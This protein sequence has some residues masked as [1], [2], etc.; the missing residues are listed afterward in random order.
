MLLRSLRKDERAGALEPGRSRRC[1]AIVVCP[2]T[3]ALGFLW[4]V[5]WRGSDRVNCHTRPLKVRHGPQWALGLALLPLAFKSLRSLFSLRRYYSALYSSVFS[6][7]HVESLVLV[8]VL[9]A[10]C[11]FSC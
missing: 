1:Q 11:S 2:L 5:W 9:V 10:S 7:Q 6:L 8:R 4:L 3:L